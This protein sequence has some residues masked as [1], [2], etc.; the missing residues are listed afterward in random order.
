MKNR[1]V[2]IFVSIAL[3]AATTPTMAVQA[4]VATPVQTESSFFATPA[5]LNLAF[6]PTATQQAVGFQELSD[7]ELSQVHGEINWGNVLG[8]AAAGTGFVL[9][10]CWYFC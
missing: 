2:A 5:Q 1:L 3:I 7:S 4:P 8:A 9:I 6:A 10:A